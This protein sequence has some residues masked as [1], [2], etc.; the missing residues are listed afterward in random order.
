MVSLP[1]SAYAD[2]SSREAK[3]NYRAAQHPK[4]SGIGSNRYN[5]DRH[6]YKPY[7][8][9]NY[10]RIYSTDNMTGKQKAKYRAAQHTKGSG[11]GT[12]RY[13]TNYYGDYPIDKYQRVFP[14]DR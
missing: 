12:N 3:A 8:S 11:I 13:N 5:T 2:N 1:L 9:S 7:Y 14:D 6:T 10:Q 4:G